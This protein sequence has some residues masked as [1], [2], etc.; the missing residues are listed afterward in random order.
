MTGMVVVDQP[1]RVLLRHG[2][3]YSL[4]APTA[5][6]L[7]TVGGHVEWVGSDDAAERW[8]D[9]ADQVIDLDGQLV[10][11]GFVDAH[12]HLALTGLSLA[13][14]D[15]SG[16][17][18]LA[19]AL[20][21]VEAYAGSQRDTVLFAHGWDETGWPEAR[22]PTIAEVD[23]AVGDRVAY[24]SRIDGHS[25][26]ISSA[27]LGEDRSI[28]DLDGWRGDGV[29]ERDAHHAAR[30]VT[31]R[32]WSPEE[33]AEALL[34]ALRHA[35]S[36]GIT[37][38]HELNAPHISAYDDFALLRWLAGAEPVPEVAPY[39]GEFRGGGHAEDATLLGFAGD[40]CADGAIGSRTACLREPYADAD[41][42][43]AGHLY[44]DSFAVAEHVVYCTE[45]GLQ[46]GF[47]VIGDRALD[48]VVAGLRRAADVVGAEAMVAARHRLEH[49]EMPT[50]EAI[51]TLAELGVVA[52][53]QPAFDA[54]WGGPDGLYERRLG[55]G[56]SAGMN[57][58]ASMRAAGVV[59][60]FG[61]DS[62]VTP[63]DPWAGVRA[64]AFHFNAEERLS[65]EAAFDAA[66]R[67]G[68]RA[69]RRD[70]AGVLTPGAEATYA[71][72]DVPAAAA[73]GLPVLDPELPLPR[74]VQ[75]VVA[76]TPIFSAEDDW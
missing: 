24:V 39:W 76:G 16:A 49:V 1:Q 52:S 60:A 22:T 12:T 7:L 30:T 56:R 19:E 58:F 34:R 20:Q 36:R 62:P 74:C 63:M 32:L 50:Q 48:E 43:T 40:L 21:Q 29:V 72:W 9:T 46:A 23:A 25:A 59:L 54:T 6:A 67:G 3:V 8:E 68:H 53:V 73:P 15:L 35:A 33:R 65:V 11:P 31:S 71:V 27:L 26:V 28:V 18:S 38:V 44:L 64:A 2:S 17:T 45:L 75:T 69:R 57:P 70:D 14:L 13:T 10:T 4:S 51:D 42:G 37:S 41:A 55:R 47:H 66:T 61:S 5:T